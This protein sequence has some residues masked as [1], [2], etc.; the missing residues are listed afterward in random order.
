MN[1]I[2]TSATGPDIGGTASMPWRSIHRLKPCCRIAAR[3][4]KRAE[5]W[6]ALLQ[7]GLLQIWWQFANTS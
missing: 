2:P 1:D 5:N 6:L 4:A 7:I 3:Y